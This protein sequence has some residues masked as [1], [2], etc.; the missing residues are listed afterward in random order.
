MFHRI[1]L[2]LKN[3]NNYKN[4]KF[5]N[6]YFLLFGQTFPPFFF[7]VPRFYSLLDKTCQ[8]GNLK[9]IN[10]FINLFVKYCNKKNSTLYQELK[11]F[12]S[13]LNFSIN[14][15]IIKVVL[16]KIGLGLKNKK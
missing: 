5:V 2:Y 15:R 1:T 4:V 12:Y 14:F 9:F 16:S 8:N 7:N 10:F 13:I 11:Q 6:Y 3:R